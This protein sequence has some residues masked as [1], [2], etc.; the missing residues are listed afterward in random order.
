MRSIL[1]KIYDYQ[2]D[3]KLS[4][5][6][7]RNLQ[8]KY[9]LWRYKIK[10]YAWTP[11]Y[12]YYKESY[13]N[14][15]INYPNLEFSKEPF[16]AYLDERCVE[17]PW[18]LHNIKNSKIILDAES[19]LNH[20]YILKILADKL[21]FITTLYPENFRGTL[22]ESY[23]YQDIRNMCYKDDYF[24][25]VT[26][27]STIEHIGFNNEGYKS[28]PNVKSSELG[29]GDFLDA[30]GEMRRVVKPSGKV[31][32]TAPFGKSYTHKSIFRQFDHEMVMSIIKKFNPSKYEYSIFKY[33]QN[34]WVKS[35]HNECKDTMY[36][37]NHSPGA[38]SVL[39]LKLIK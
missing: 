27:V 1:G 13:I 35:N 30:V 21:F 31:L 22:G 37:D 16:G 15:L 12:Q 32:I 7:P 6:L 23:V 2:L 20:P 28:S 34:H 8:K 36:R 5:V 17:I 19:A 3:V 14:D 10:H 11:G 25:S 39:L 29:Q 33:S 18:A 4:R 9:L 38:G 24:D 26:C